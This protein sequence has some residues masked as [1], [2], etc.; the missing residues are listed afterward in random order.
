MAHQA[1]SS[2]LQNEFSESFTEGLA[3]ALVEEIASTWYG[4]MSRLD[5]PERLDLLEEIVRISANEPALAPL[6]TARLIERLGV[7][8]IRCREQAQFYLQSA[9]DECRRAALEWGR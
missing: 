5:W 2:V 3:E 8:P 7:E 1:R 9:D 6:V 4:A